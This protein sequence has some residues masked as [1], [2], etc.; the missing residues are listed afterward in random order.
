[1]K[2][3]YP[4][5]A[6]RDLVSRLRRAVPDLALTTDIIVGFCGEGDDDF[7]RTCDLMEEIRFDSAFTFRYSE[8]SGTEAARRRA[9]DVPEAVKGERL[10]RVIDLQERIS[11]EI[12]QDAVGRPVEVLVEGPSRRRDESGRATY[13]GRSRQGKVTVFREP[14][15]ASALVLVDVD[16][17]TSHTLLGAR[18][19]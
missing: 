11:W 12:N 2:G 13:Y 6:S 1:M 8:R 17:A 7:R 15:P 4:L 16:R 3:G 18:R 14:T 10:R 5:A 9:D 19:P